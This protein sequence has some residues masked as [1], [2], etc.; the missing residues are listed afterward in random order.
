MSTCSPEWSRTYGDG[1]SPTP[2]SSALA[3]RWRWAARPSRGLPCRVL[4][5]VGARVGQELGDQEAR[6]VGVADAREQVGGGVLGEGALG[7]L[8]VGDEAVDRDD[9][10]RPGEGGRAAPSAATRGWRRCGAGPGRRRA[11]SRPT[12][13]GP[14]TGPSGR[15]GRGGPGEGGRGR[16]EG[17]PVPARPAASSQFLRLG[18]PPQVRS[19][20]PSRT[21]MPINA[22][23]GNPVPR[24]IR[25]TVTNR[26][27]PAGG[28]W[29]SGSARGG[30]RAGACAAPTT[31]GS[32]PSSPTGAGGARPPCR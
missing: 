4:A 26:V 3:V 5:P 12:G 1:L 14:A 13:P 19:T 2:F 25:E 27:R 23:S 9:G 32:R 24:N 18:V 10:L 28:R 21:S 17:R 6:V 8:Q 20:D 7:L 15:P 30:W 11:G 22:E 31:R 16:P 29:P